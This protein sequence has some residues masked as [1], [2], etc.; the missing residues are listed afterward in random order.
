MLKKDTLE[1]KS[2][3]QWNKTTKPY[4][5]SQHSSG[6]SGP[7]ILAK[8]ASTHLSSEDTSEAE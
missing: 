4:S 8:V 1:E 2:S 3:S 7:R 6:R 5:Q